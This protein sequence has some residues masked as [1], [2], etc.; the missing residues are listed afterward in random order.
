MDW[1]DLLKVLSL[2]K[3][4]KKKKDKKK[5]FCKCDSWGKGN[6][7]YEWIEPMSPTLAGEF[8][9]TSVTWEARIVK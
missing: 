1:L 7:H 8:F 5:T 4:K 3:L 6:L 2:H 9:L